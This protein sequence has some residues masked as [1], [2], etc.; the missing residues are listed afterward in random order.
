V[1]VPVSVK[2]RST[3]SLFRVSSTFVNAM[4]T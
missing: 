4:N 1:T 2:E 3:L